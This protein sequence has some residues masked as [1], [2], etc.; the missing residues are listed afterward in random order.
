M[1][2][3]AEHHQAL[4]AH[5]EFRHSGIDSTAIDPQ[6]H[7]HDADDQGKHKGS[8]RGDFILQTGTKSARSIEQ[9]SSQKIERDNE[10][11]VGT[12]IDAEQ[13]SHCRQCSGKSY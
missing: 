12:K 5:H 9:E 7:T 1:N 13:D 2:E 8:H 4:C 11:R 10:N 3:P 6:G